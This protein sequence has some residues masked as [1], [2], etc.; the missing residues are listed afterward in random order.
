MN[1]PTPCPT[2]RSTHHA[3]CGEC[4][5][6]RRE[7]W[8]WNRHHSIDPALMRQPAQPVRNHIRTL[9]N[10]GMRLADIATAAGM[11]TTGQIARVMYSGR[12]SV[13]GATAGRI[14]AIRPQPAADRW[15]VD[16][17]GTRRRAQ[18]L[19]RAGWALGGLARRLGYTPT[20]GPRWA[21]AAQVTQATRDKVAAL[22]DELSTLD[23][24]CNRAARHAERQGWQPPE[25]WSDDTI[26]NPAAQPYDW[27]RDDVD[28]VAV[29]KV[30]RGELSWGRLTDA[31][32]RALFLAHGGQV[33][34]SLVA[35]WGTTK[36]NLTRFANRL[37][38]QEAA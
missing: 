19:A 14:L 12:R 18:A 22:Y 3:G 24:G 5:R 13:T 9:L 1:R 37:A 17:T 15:L 29:A 25:A 10:S 4:R 7:R 6:Y 33:R 35:R 8:H 28:E 30:N 23:G 38:E 16:G 27:C 2:H 31:E 26:D 36:A 20:F 34:A 11:A 21:H 32:K